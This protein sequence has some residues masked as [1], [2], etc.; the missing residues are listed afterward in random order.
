MKRAIIT[1][2]TGTIGV[3]LADILTKNGCEVYAVCRPN[4]CN[5]KNLKKHKNLFILECDISDLLSLKEKISKDFD[6][7]YH[8]AWD[9]TFGDSRNEVDLQINNVKYTL[10]AVRLAK[11]L[12]C[13]VFIGA[14]SQAEYGHYNRPADENTKTRPFTLYGAAKLSAGQL[15]RVY[16]QNLKINHIWVRIFSVFGPGDD[17]R[18]LVSYV[19]DELN[20]G[21]SPE[22][23]LGEQIWDY[24]YSYDA[25][26]AMIKIAEKGKNNSIY[27]LAS[28]Q[29]RRLKEYI[30]DIADVVNPNINIVFGNKPYSK[31][32]IMFLSAD[33]S[34]LKNDTGFIPKYN[35]KQAIKKIIDKKVN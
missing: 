2:S 32:Q 27:C 10:D 25:A 18:T 7:F 3:A 31:N 11:S 30:K 12:N 14:G 21:K 19:I 35:F 13:K 22:L 6:V 28:G 4:S 34:K 23:T 8:L 29:K 16:A 15:S 17:S 9:G 20:H 33:I 5:I 1:G 26:D 24:I